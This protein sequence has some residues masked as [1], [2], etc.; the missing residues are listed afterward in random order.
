MLFCP[1]AYQSARLTRE[2][3]H[4]TLDQLDEDFAEAE[5][6]GKNLWIGNKCTYHIGYLYPYIIE[7]KDLVWVYLTRVSGKSTSWQVNFC[8]KNKKMTSVAMKS[9]KKAKRIAEV[10]NNRF[11]HIV[12]GFNEDL[13]GFLNLRYNQHA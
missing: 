10:Y 4:T 12:V 5:Y 8:D 1:L 6:I 13:E 9:K 2:T 3:H 7:N 11:P